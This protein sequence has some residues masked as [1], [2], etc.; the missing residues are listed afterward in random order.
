MWAHRFRFLFFSLVFA[1][2]LCCALFPQ[3]RWVNHFEVI[4]WIYA[5]SL[6][7]PKRMHYMP[8]LY[9]FDPLTPFIYFLPS[10]P[11]LCQ[12]AAWSRSCRRKSVPTTQEWRGFTSTKGYECVQ[13]PPTQSHPNTAIT[14]LQ[15]SLPALLIQCAKV[16]FFSPHLHRSRWISEDSLSLS[17]SL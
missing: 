5:E 14:Q 2:P 9:A 4:M 12:S 11:A 8:T 6:F 13:P 7:L 10:N 16:K 17:A 15:A 1:T 3:K